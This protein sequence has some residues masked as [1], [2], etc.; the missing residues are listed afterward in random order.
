M[1][2]PWFKANLLEGNATDRIQKRPSQF[3]DGHT[4]KTPKTAEI[5][6]LLTGG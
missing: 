6:Y 2:L 3:C 5:R 1:V 4:V